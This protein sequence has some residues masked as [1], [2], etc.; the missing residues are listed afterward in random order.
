ME[1]IIVVVNNIDSSHD[2]LD[3]VDVILGYALLDDNRK[4][5]SSPSQDVIIMENEEKE[6]HM[7][8]PLKMKRRR[9][10]LQQMRVSPFHK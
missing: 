7:R 4:I 6:K 9:M 10:T 1:Y 8:G 3:I 5:K 2:D